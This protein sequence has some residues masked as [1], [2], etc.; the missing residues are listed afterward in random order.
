MK[1]FLPMSLGF[2]IV[3]WDLGPP[4]TICSTLS[5]QD[6]SGNITTSL[7]HE[8]HGD[9]KYSPLRAHRWMHVAF[10][11]RLKEKTYGVPEPTDLFVDGN[12][13]LYV[14]FGTSDFW[15]LSGSFGV[16]A[17]VAQH[18]TWDFNHVRLGGPSVIGANIPDVPY[19]GNTSSDGTFDELFI[20]NTD[21]PMG[22]NSAQVMWTRGR[23]YKPSGA[24]EGTFTSQAI[25]LA[26]SGG[27]QL[28]PASSVS[29]PPGAPPVPPTVPPTSTPSV[30][31]LGMGW[32]WY[33][34]PLDPTVTPLAGWNGKPV[35]YDYS[36][37]SP[38]GSPF[39]DVKPKV[40][41]SI[42][43]PGI[44][45]G[46]YYGEDGFSAVKDAAGSPPV[47]QNPGAIK[48]KARFILAEADLSTILLATPVLD[49]VT[50]YFED[51]GPRIVSYV[52]D[53]GR[54]F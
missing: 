17:S 31:L 8:G 12:A 20:W 13:S 27:H 24:G 30:R 53:V 46:V 50:L 6:D 33:G 40:E 3:N 48:Y 10:R 2:G 21:S 4:G 42:E 1:W 35:L 11:H 28:A 5:D 39:K 45:P 54:A 36:S 32:T 22:S 19:H 44:P 16:I 29:P 38:P 43:D 7:N 37:V 51:G 34:E 25:N 14:P 15:G 18:Q 23:Y 47:L 52:C 26:F 9:G 49:D 41:L